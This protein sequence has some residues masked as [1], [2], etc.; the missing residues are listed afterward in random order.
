MTD[1]QAATTVVYNSEKQKFLLVRRA[2]SKDRNPGLWE[3]PGGVVEED[4]TPREAA[5]RELHEETGLKG[6][7]LKTGD[8][9]IIEADIGDIEIHPFLI[10]VQSSRVELSREHTE[11]QW[12]SRDE[13]DSFETVKGL[14]KELE[15]VGIE[16]E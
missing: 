6:E 3:F 14:E 13:L 7:I 12:I 11:H 10:L 15:A 1:F 5:I 4:E 2:D 9:G 8:S 16:K